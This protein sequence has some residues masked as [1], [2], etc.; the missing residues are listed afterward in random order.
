MIWLNSSGNRDLVWVLLKA[1]EVGTEEI[2]PNL[3]EQDEFQ[4]RIEFFASD[5]NPGMFSYVYFTNRQL[6]N[7]FF[8]GIL[9]SPYL[10]PR[11]LF[12][13]SLV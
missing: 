5:H 4:V 3:T 11:S 8:Q 6:K 10:L 2:K 9:R 7:G 1:C 12:T 13:V